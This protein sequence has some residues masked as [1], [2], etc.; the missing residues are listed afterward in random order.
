MP[1]LSVVLPCWGRELLTMRIL[2]SIG[3]QTLNDYELFLFGDKCPVFEKIIHSSEYRELKSSLKGKVFEKNFETHDGTSAQAIN[4][5]IKICSGEYF[6]FL[7]NDDNIF[8]D[9][10]ESYY[11]NSLKSKTYI[12]F[13]NTYIDNGSG[14][15]STRVPK[16]HP[17]GVGHSELCVKTEVIKT[18]PPHSRNYGHD[19]EFIHYA[20]QSGFTH[21]FHNNTPTYIVNLGPREHNWE[22]GRVV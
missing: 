3:L 1:K 22:A 10:F 21:D 13:F 6:I 16:L 18:A 8:P 2:N 7:S 14:V 9:H 15:L 4:E 11:S 12:N 20:I 19:W 5:A 17:G